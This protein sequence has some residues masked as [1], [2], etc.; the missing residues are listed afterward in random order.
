MGMDMI[1][2]RINSSIKKNHSRGLHEGFYAACI[3]QAES[4]GCFYF[5]YHEKK[6]KKV[7]TMA[8]Q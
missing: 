3:R 2:T 1:I 7:K 5:L 8:F 6:L 4:L